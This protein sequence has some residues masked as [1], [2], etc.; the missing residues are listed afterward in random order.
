MKKTI[1]RILIIAITCALLFQLNVSAGY[2]LTLETK[3]DATTYAVGG[4]VTTTVDW[5][6]NLQAAGFTLRFNSTKLSFESA[7]VNDNYYSI[8]EPTVDETSGDSYTNIIVSWTSLEEVD[9]TSISFQFKT[10]ESGDTTILVSDA[11]VDEFSNENLERPEQID[12]TTK[13]SKTIKITTLGDVDLNGK[14]NNLDKIILA[15]YIDGWEGEEYELNEEALSNADVCTDGIVDKFDYEILN[16]YLSGHAIS[17]PFIYGDVNCDGRV[18]IDDATELQ[19]YNFPEGHYEL[20]REGLNR[21]DVNLD[22]EVNEFDRI[23]IQRHLAELQ[24][25][26]KL[27][28]NI[29]ESNNGIRKYSLEY[30]PIISGFD[31]SNTAISNIKQQL[32]SNLKIDVY[33]TNDEKIEDD[34]LLATGYKLKIDEKTTEEVPE[35]L[36]GVIGEYTSVIYGDTTGDGKINAIDALALIKDINNK[37]PFTSEVYRQAGRIVSTNDQNPT[38]VDALAIIK[39]ANGKYVINQNK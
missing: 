5:G 17:F 31:I 2:S 22:G 7:S 15:R 9:T 25:Y 14:I 1:L 28:V 19:R 36:A 13:G 23:T 24:N 10:L 37:I 27:P 18:S 21:A 32:T 16:R 20:S 33:N 38:A 6:H 12:Y 3:T 30:G 26:S 4:T 8:S 35:E 34:K 29:S 39:A 11:S